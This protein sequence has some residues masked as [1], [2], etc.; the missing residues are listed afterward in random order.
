MFR[1][2][3]ITSFLPNDN[4]EDNN[5]LYKLGIQDARDNLEKLKEMFLVNE[6]N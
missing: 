1:Q 4:I 2:F 5:K 6:N 3:P